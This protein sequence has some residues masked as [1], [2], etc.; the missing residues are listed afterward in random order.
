MTKLERTSKKCGFIVIKQIRILNY[1]Y[2]NIP[3]KTLR[4][5]PPHHTLKF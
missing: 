1:F 5:Y 2:S 4:H 3:D